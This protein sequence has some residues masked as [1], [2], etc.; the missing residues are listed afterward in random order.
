MASKRRS[1]DVRHPSTG[2]QKISKFAAFPTA[3]YLYSQAFQ[4]YYAYNPLPVKDYLE[5]CSAE[6]KPSI[7]L[8]MCGDI[9][10]CFYTIWKNLDHSISN[11]PKRFHGVEFTLNDRSAAVQARNIVFL[12]LC[13]QLP[14]TKLERKKWISAMWA[15]W[16]CHELH[17]Y[18]ETCLDFSLRFLLKFSTSL[19]KWTSKENHMN[20]LVK[21]TSPTCLSNIAQVWKMWHENEVDVSSVEKMQESRERKLM[22]SGIME[23]LES[24]CFDSA[25][26][27][28]YARQLN[29]KDMLTNL[30]LQQNRIA[31]RQEEIKS[32][33][34]TGNCFC[35][36]ALGLPP[37]ENPQTSVN[38]TLYEKQ[39]KGYHQQCVA[40]P[41]RRYHQTIE[42]SY[43]SFKSKENIPNS[44]DFNVLPES[45]E[46]VPFL[47]NSI[48]QFSLWVQST[49]RVLKDKGISVSFLFSTQDSLTFCQELHLIQKRNDGSEV[50]KVPMYNVIATSNL[51]DY[52]GP[53]NIVLST[54]PLL[55]DEGLLFTTTWLYKRSFNTVEEYLKAG[56]GFDCQMFPVILGAR[57]INHEGIEFA[58]PILITPTPPSL[59]DL[60]EDFEHQREMIWQKVSGAQ[61][62][63][64]PALPPVIKGNISSALQDLMHSCSHQFYSDYKILMNRINIESALLILVHFISTSCNVTL[65]NYAFWD[66]LRETLL[67]E[68]GPFLH[69]IQTQM[70]LHNIHA[71][72]TVTESECPLC[73][74][75]PL[76]DS[77]VSICFKMPL[78]SLVKFNIIYFVAV[79]HKTSS[80]S[81]YLVKEAFISKDIH[82]FDC[83][84][85]IVCN[86]M[87]QIQL[88]V[89]QHLVQQNYK[90]SVVQVIPKRDNGNTFVHQISSGFLKDVQ[91]SS[92]KYDFI[93]PEY[94]FNPHKSDF[95]VVSAH[96]CDSHTSKTII[97]LSKQAIRKLSTDEI[98]YADHSASEMEISCR[99]LSVQL[100]F[101]YPIHHNTVIISRSKDDREMNITCYRYGY[102][103][104]EESAGFVVSPDH[105]FSL[106]PFKL[107][108]AMVE[109][110]ASGQHTLPENNLCQSDKELSLP[111]HYQ[112][113][114][115]LQSIF[116]GCS[117]SCFYFQLVNLTGKENLGY[118]IVNKVMFDCERRTPVIDLA[119]CVLNKH[120]K[121]YDVSKKWKKIVHP[122]NLADII[123]IKMVESN[124]EILFKVF[125]YFM[126]YTNGSLLSAGSDSRYHILRHLN[127]SHLF[128]RA[129]I[130]FL[131]VDPDSPHTQVG[132]THFH[133]P[134]LRLSTEVKNCEFCKKISAN[135]ELCNGCKKVN[136]CSKRCQSKH[137]AEHHSN[138]TPENA[139]EPSKNVVPRTLKEKITNP[140]LKETETLQK[141]CTH[142]KKTPDS[143]IKCP[144]C[145]AVEYCNEECHTNHL[146]EHKKVCIQDCATEI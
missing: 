44:G 87:L 56:F 17:S 5:S 84:D 55:K 120:S 75:I 69:T 85:S 21:F 27:A 20:H 9:L 64:F 96:I 38:L 26:I 90:I 57:C 117:N 59:A 30:A 77:V 125:Q 136:Y 70:L 111:S 112:I 97:T 8:L 63:T 23:K 99:T 116:E 58:S 28:S 115:I 88:F 6:Q 106:P 141:A 32:Y 103:F 122:T 47:A 42:F 68:L 61:K 24:Y 14:E 40:A 104:E 18:H 4:T 7:L 31:I 129:A 126:K 2:T 12:H 33:I 73:K 134:T 54:L 142:C 45:F 124:L 83:L 43:N 66:P 128:C 123:S 49:H 11:A 35:E 65:S 71:H 144:K 140:L 34:L 121:S 36:T 130:Y 92:V 1:R 133:R 67:K 93:K 16:Y 48:Q 60:I 78:D 50:Q 131:L 46:S 114:R 101:S 127:V 29:T 139:S 105:H 80:D 145:G 41:Y 53:P 89:P 13:L 25:W 146:P 110:H 135:E 118:I 138:C 107:N 109:V 119:Y 79:I 100:K 132:S 22:Q 52:L 91:S 3:R 143:L 95:G 37:N 108:T 51:I 76:E 98:N 82:I 94:S 137:W 74:Q 62:Q 81:G 86:E 39:N 102:F 72:L 19:K 15:I 113:K 10:S